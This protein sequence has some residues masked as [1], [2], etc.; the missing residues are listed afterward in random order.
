MTES[1]P[2]LERRFESL[3]DEVRALGARVDGLV[4]Q[5]T[6][7]STGKTPAVEVAP[8]EE[9]YV[10]HLPRGP[11]E[12]SGRTFLSSV[13]TVS[14]LLVMALILRW[15]ANQEIM[16]PQMASLLGVTYAGSLIIIG[17]VRYTR[18]PRRAV[19][20]Y[21]TSGT[22]LL[23]SIVFE[24]YY[25][26]EWISAPLAYGVLGLTVIV[27][28]IFGLRFRAATPVSVA[29]L[30]AS[31][32]GLVL[33]FPSPFFPYL[34]ALLFVANVAAYLALR[35]PRC[36]WLLG[37]VFMVTLFFWLMWTV[38]VRAPLLDGEVPSAELALPWLLPFVAGFALLY[39]LMALASALRGPQPLGPFMSALPLLN[40]L[41][42]YAVA[43]GVASAVAGAVAR[44]VVLPGQGWTG[45]RAGVLAA[46]LHLLL[47]FWV[48]RGNSGRT[49]PGGRTRAGASFAAAAVILLVA[50][51]PAATGNMPVTVL[52]WTGVGLSLAL[53]S[54]FWQNRAIRALSFGLQGWACTAAIVS[55]SLACLLP[56]PVD[57]VAVAVLAFASCVAHYGWC[58]TR[59]AEPDAAY[60]DIFEVV[61]LLVALGYAFGAGRMAYF[62]FLGSFGV[63]TAGAFQCG[64][65]ILINVAALVLMLLGLRWMSGH[66]QVVAAVVA[67]AGALKV[68]AY[69]LVNISDLPLVLSVSSFALTAAVA[70]LVWGRWQRQTAESAPETSHHE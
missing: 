46:A 15:I 40:A 56:L 23:F 50:S 29:V 34:P 67:V 43:S 30:G 51:L 54:V 31:V 57:N 3:V 17:F 36:R 38:K 5:V 59:K 53:M 41:W 68:F 18:R 10:P 7:L 19:P 33:V 42:A 60:W 44:G 58:R 55:G 13:S 37:V 25:R 64:Q 2:S 47:A 48:T 65:S 32:L 21:I 39:V 4:E 70:S 22:L 66:V 8:I 9:A 63:E 61:L 16:P 28:T 6:A 14:F 24:T 12:L 69:D 49:R 20:L 26:F 27:M 11:E 62:A 45:H 52:V 35:I 1:D